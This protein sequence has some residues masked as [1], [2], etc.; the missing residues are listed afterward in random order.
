MLS[1]FAASYACIAMRHKNIS[2]QRF[3]AFTFAHSQFHF[4]H[5]LEGK[6]KRE[7]NR[8]RKGNREINRPN[9]TCK[10][11][12]LPYNQNGI[13]KFNRRNDIE[14]GTRLLLNDYYVD[15]GYGYHN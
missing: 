9:H 1:Y 7:R 11:T 5:L 12:N 10:I 3:S 8:D 6:K 2:S 15:A 14:N 13:Y 4:V